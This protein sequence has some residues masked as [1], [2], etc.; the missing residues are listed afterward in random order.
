MLRWNRDKPV[1]CSVKKWR[2]IQVMRF[3]EHNPDAKGMRVKDWLTNEHEVDPWPDVS[4]KQLNKSI[5]R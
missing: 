3:L 1:G 2:C 4:I 5:S